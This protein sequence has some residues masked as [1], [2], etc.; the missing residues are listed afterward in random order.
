MFPE[1]ADDGAYTITLNADFTGVIEFE[2]T[3]ED[4]TDD[5]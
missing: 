1:T 3:E 5:D 4:G 2:K